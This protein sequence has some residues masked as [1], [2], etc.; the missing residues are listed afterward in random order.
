M[1]YVGRKYIGHNHWSLRA[2]TPL[3]SARRSVSAATTP[4]DVLNGQIRRFSGDPV[5]DKAK[6]RV[7]G[8]NPTALFI[9]K[10]TLFGMLL[11]DIDTFYNLDYI[12]HIRKNP[13]KKKTGA[14]LCFV[15]C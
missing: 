2:G 9:A 3:V 8:G 5:P 12:S 6:H 15:A 13:H 11:V 1:P 14:I 7:R 10:D 4:H